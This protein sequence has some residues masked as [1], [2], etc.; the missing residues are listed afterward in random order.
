[1]QARW[2]GWLERLIT[3]RVPLPRYEEALHRGPENVKVV[4][5][6]AAGHDDARAADTGHGRSE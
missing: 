6:V 3:R 1:V 5:D 4:I 2:P